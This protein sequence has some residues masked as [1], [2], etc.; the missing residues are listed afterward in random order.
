MHRF[1]PLSCT[2]C[3][4]FRWNLEVLDFLAHMRGQEYIDDREVS[5]AS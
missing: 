3:N 1:L 5:E 4:L 2:L